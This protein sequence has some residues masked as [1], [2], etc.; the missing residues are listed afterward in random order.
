M[1]VPDPVVLVAC[2]KFKGSLVATEVAQ[3][4]AVGVR[5]AL[6]DATVR[7]LLVADGGDGTIEAALGAGY[8]AR[9]T[10]TSG[11]TGRPLQARYAVLGATAV[12][13]LAETC[14]IVHLPDRRL[15]PLTS[16]SRGV[17]E[18][19]RAALDEGCAE[20]VLGIGGSASTDGGTG[21]LS[22]LGARFLDASGHEIP[23]G[24]G[25]LATLDRVDLSGLHPALAGARVVVACDVNNP[26]LGDR[27]TAAVFGPQK[28]V[29]EQLRPQVDA[30]LERLAD[31]LAEATG[32]D[33]RDE[34]GAGAAGG[35]GYA[36]LQVLD[37]E[38]RPGVELVLDLVGFAEQVDGADLVITGEGSLDEQ[39]LMG[40]TP[41][42][43]AEAA[44]RAGVPVVAVCGRS[45]LAGGQAEAAGVRRVYALTDIEPD[46]ARC[47][48]AA[49][50]LL[51]ELAAAVARDLAD[52]RL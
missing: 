14:G 49:G 31:L 37:V 48:S 44:A 50:P 40:K 13:E 9:T 2:D 23:D 47:M 28:G 33:T 24:A 30:G 34:P 3:R 36:A 11:P 39:S 42:G 29:T 41:V 32:R 19:V 38:M 22:A 1:T 52:G 15:E 17:G 7:S 6:P 46:L 4:V 12:V 45:L 51:E 25:G 21:M 10:T 20:I 18:A 27:G 8:E 16:T 35:V 43:V 5:R 26:L